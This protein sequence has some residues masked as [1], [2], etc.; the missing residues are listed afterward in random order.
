MPLRALE[1]ACEEFTRP[2]NWSP[3]VE[4]SENETEFLVRAEMPD[5]LGGDVHVNVGDGVLAISGTRHVDPAAQQ[6]KILRFDGANDASFQRSFGL[7][8]GVDAA[9]VTAEFRSGQLLVHLPKTTNN[10]LPTTTVDAA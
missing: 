8:H 1:D 10:T 6:T 7:P 2:S 9:S 4:I 3:I 5:A